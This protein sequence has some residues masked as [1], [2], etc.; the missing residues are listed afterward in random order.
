LHEFTENNTPLV[1][2][3]NIPFVYA[4][5]DIE[6]LL[7]KKSCQIDHPDILKMALNGYNIDVRHQYMSSFNGNYVDKPV[8]IDLNSDQY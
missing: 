1:I 2:A 3:R 6:L 8:I 5:K 4:G 7:P